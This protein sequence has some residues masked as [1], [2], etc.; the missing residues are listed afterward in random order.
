M[1]TFVT[2]YLDCHNVPYKIKHH[3]RPVFTS[4]AAARER[5]VR[6]S[7]IVKT[8]LLVSQD[9]TIV[10]AV[11]PGNKKLD[12]KKLKK[13]GGHK[14]LQL[15][16]KEHI[17]KRFGIVV[18]AVAPVG[19]IIK[20]FPVFVDRSVFEEEVVDISSGDPKAGLEL[21]REDL[22]GLL[23]HATVANIAKED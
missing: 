14:S 12:I 13:L 8:M 17:E 6:L 5:G 16:D 1:E 18:G 10:V 2:D 7:Q 9:D 20:G 22:K 11:V 4:E 15:M 23:K 3:T 21:H 19:G